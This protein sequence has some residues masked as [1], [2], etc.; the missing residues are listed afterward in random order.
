[1]KDVKCK[2]KNERSEMFD[3][4]DCVKSYLKKFTHNI[5]RERER[6]RERE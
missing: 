4:K 1:M 5:E 3:L 2:T 6:E